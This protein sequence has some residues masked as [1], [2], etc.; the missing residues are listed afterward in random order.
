MEEHK[1]MMA[2]HIKEMDI[3]SAHLAAIRV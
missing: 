1:A 2:E 3:T